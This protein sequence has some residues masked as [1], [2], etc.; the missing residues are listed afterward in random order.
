MQDVGAGPRGKRVGKNA[1]RAQKEDV[2][3]FADWQTVAP[4]VPIADF[5]FPSDLVRRLEL[6]HFPVVAAVEDDD[7]VVQAEH[8]TV[9]LE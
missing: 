6:R 2:V 7:V 4:R 8:A 3:P 5:L 1:I 9:V